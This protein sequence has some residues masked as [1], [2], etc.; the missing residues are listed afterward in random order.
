MDA[1]GLNPS[2][3]RRARWIA[4]LLLASLALACNK[5]DDADKP[6]KAAP[7]EADEPAAAEP[8]AEPTIEATA[9]KPDA[10]VLPRL[11]AWL[12]A[13]AL[14]VSF[15]RLEQRF[16]PAVLEVVF[17]LPPKAAHLIAERRTLDDA[18]AV[19]FEGEAA[20]NGW[21]GPQSLAFTV[22]LA[23]QPYFVRPLLRPLAEVTP[24]LE[25]AGFTR[26]DIEG[27]GVWL[28]DG[29][30]PWRLAELDD[31][32]LGFIPVEVAGAGLEPFLTASTQP[33]STIETQLADALGN[34]PFIQLTLLSGGPLLHYDVDEP[35]NQ[36]Q[37]ALRRATPSG[38]MW[39]GQVVLMP[40]GDVDE[41]GN[42]LRAR[43]YPEENQQIQALLKQV[44]FV[45]E[46]PLVIGRLQITSDL[47]K[48]FRER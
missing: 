37:F 28:P 45:V 33:A 29:A 41:C 25:Q 19:V 34:D 27:V 11:L 1:A 7:T 17:A 43:S 15:D 21:L 10:D 40:S 31:R 36:V 12:P 46:K 18:L 6:A 26:N 30:F 48:H 14:A 32:T 5:Q 38:D 2:K 16:D 22:P 23:K 42:Q 3:S 39:E 8:K 24:L 13:E 35:I 20:A 4:P 47:L 44:E 9:A